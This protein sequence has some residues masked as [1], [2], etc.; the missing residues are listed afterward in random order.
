M[1]ESTMFSC[2]EETAR[3]GESCI[4]NLREALHIMEEEPE[5]SPGRRFLGPL[6]QLLRLHE[7]TLADVMDFHM[8]RHLDD[9]HRSCRRM[10]IL[11]S[12]AEELSLSDPRKQ[13]RAQKLL[14]AASLAAQRGG[15]F[16]QVSM[17]GGLLDHLGD[18]FPASTR[19]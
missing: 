12:V 9:H 2:P 18:D 15:I 8:M 17:P 6:T 14:R 16:C 5:G 7:A 13:A 10:A 19:E 4:V 1:I 11:P 3:E